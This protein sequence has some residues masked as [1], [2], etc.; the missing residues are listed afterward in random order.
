MLHVQMRLFNQADGKQRVAMNSEITFNIG[1][2][3]FLALHWPYF[4]QHPK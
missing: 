3:D 4:L 1:N 2:S